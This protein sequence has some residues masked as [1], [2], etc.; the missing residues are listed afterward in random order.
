MILAAFGWTRSLDPVSFKKCNPTQLSAAARTIKTPYIMHLPFFR[1]VPPAFRLKPLLLLW[2]TAAFFGPLFGQEEPA[3]PK[4]DRLITKGR[5]Y[6][7]LSFSLDQRRAENESQF[8]Q[9]VIDQDRLRYRVTVN[10]GYA[11]GNNLTLGLGLSYGRDR[12]DLTFL[13]D[14]EEVTSRF[15]EQD[16][17]FIPNMRNYIPFGNG[18]FQ[19]FV[20]SDMRFSFVESL[21]RDFF[22]DEVDKIE[23]DVFEYRLG[24]SPG[25]L[26]FFDRH[27]AFEMSV[28]LAG[29]TSRI[30]RETTNDDED[31]RTRVVKTDIDLQIN[32]LA[33]NLGVAYYF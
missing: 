4:D 11:V 30:T 22:P 1:R 23:R 16:I 7:S 31:N 21:Q 32:L 20:Q 29:L 18:T 24:V 33:L 3:K 2:L 19:I 25:V 8:L 27:W 14:G 9:E 10:G 5:A 17:S 15:L 28:G 6:V 12:E 13:Q 26:L